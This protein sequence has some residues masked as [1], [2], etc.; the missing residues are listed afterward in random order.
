MISSRIISPQL[1][2]KSQ[3]EGS[4]VAKQRSLKK[5]KI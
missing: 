3:A 2:A 4:Q 1:M 5:E